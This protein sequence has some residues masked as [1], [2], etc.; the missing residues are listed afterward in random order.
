MPDPLLLAF[1]S[2]INSG[3]KPFRYVAKRGTSAHSRGKC[4][5]TASPNTPLILI[6]CY[7][8]TIKLNGGLFLVPPSQSN[9]LGKKQKNLFSP[10]PRHPNISIY[11]PMRR[12][13]AGKVL[14]F[15]RGYSNRNISVYNKAGLATQGSIEM[16][17]DELINQARHLYATLQV[18]QY[19]RYLENKIQFDRFDY[20]VM[21]A[22]CRYQRRLNRCVLCYQSRLAD[23]GREFVDCRRKHC[24][25]LQWHNPS[26]QLL[27]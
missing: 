6:V 4:G 11:R 9:R 16:N 7:R 27:E 26:E 14:L 2:S 24:P 5:L 17:N 18:K 15:P 12:F 13:F 10:P 19:T 3:E 22:Y 21:Y 25:H 1:K 23:C 8:R 20:L